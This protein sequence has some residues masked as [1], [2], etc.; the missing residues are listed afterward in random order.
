MFKKALLLA[1][2]LFA[3]H[4]LAQNPTC[5][6]RPAG[7]S[8]NACAST[9][10]VQ[11]AFGSGVTS[12][13]GRTGAVLPATNDYNFNQIAGTVALSQGGLGGSQAAA[14]ANQIPVYP[15]SAGAAVPTSAPTWFD[16]AYCNTIGYLIV[17]IANAWTCNNSI[18]ANVDWFANVFA[19][20]TTDDT[21]GVNA[22]LAAVNGIVNFS[23]KVYCAKSGSGFTTTKANQIIQ[24]TGGTLLD[25]CGSDNSTLTANGDSIIVRNMSINVSA[26]LAVTTNHNPLNF[27][28]NCTRCRGEHVDT[29][30]GYYNVLINA[31]YTGVHDLR[32]GNAHG[33]AVVKLL[34]SG[35]SSPGVFMDFSQIDQTWPCS[36]PSNLA[37]ISAWTN[38]H[39]YSANAVVS[40]NGY[41]LQ[42]CAG[43][44][45]A[46]VA[47][48]NL[49]YGNNITDNT[50]TWRLVAPTTFDGL[51]IDTGAVNNFIT[52]SD[53]TGPYTNGVHIH[54]SLAG[55]APISTLLGFGNTYAQ[56]LTACVNAEAGSIL[57]ISGGQNQ[58]QNGVMAATIGVWLKS[59][60][61]GNYQIESMV[62]LALGNSSAGILDQA[63][64]GNGGTIAN[65]LIYNGA[66]GISIGANI[67]N[68]TIS[69]N[70]GGSS[71]L[72]TN[73]VCIFVS[74]GTGDYLN[75]LPN[76]CNGA[77]SAQIT[78][79]GVIGIHNYFC[80]AGI[81][82]S[83][84]S[85]SNVINSPPVTVNFGSAG[86]TALPIPLPPGFTA[87]LTTQVLF[88]NC[89]ASIAGATY[90]VFTT[91]GGGGT[92]IIPAGTSPTV[93]A[94]A[95]NTNNNGAVI[96]ATN[97]N[98]QSY[99]PV[100]G[101]FQ[102]RVG[103]TAVAT[104]LVYVEYKPAAL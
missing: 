90:G 41:Y 78:V 59:T 73:T 6:T 19:N 10:F 16:N 14:T 22:V 96:N 1:L 3:T 82:G 86:D 13:N 72:G 42:T 28:P 15:G 56:N 9:A 32:T 104:C 43:G 63:G 61:T 85:A 11:G 5:P 49:D 70:H 75:I 98:T 64:A 52:R 4:A 68:R 30:G 80:N 23:S 25:T 53:F 54:N 21:A 57:T 29:A 27:G 92:A 69:G 76:D 89:T 26:G 39:V 94:T 35:G 67:N 87:T 33:P 84:T 50:V 74:P 62:M 79:A 8:T 91:T 44:T 103:A 99:T 77:S 31:A 81:C 83:S 45:S 17:R 66:T 58:C 71:S 36:V 48:A 34:S 88:S 2:V 55:T 38:A 18:P 95:A 65:N 12:F 101:N 37:S 47:P 60:F 102:F 46:G 24:G 20:G 93:T 7:D 97:V 40:N 100:G 51:S